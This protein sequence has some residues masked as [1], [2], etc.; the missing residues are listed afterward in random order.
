[1]PASVS[2]LSTTYQS[3]DTLGRVQLYLGGGGR[4]LRFGVIVRFVRDRLRRAGSGR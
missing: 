2:L 1:M 4:V 3:R